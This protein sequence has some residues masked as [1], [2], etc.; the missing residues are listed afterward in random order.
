MR[1]LPGGDSDGATHI[2][3]MVQRICSLSWPASG[4]INLAIG[5]REIDLGPEELEEVIKQIR[6]CAK[7]TSLQRAPPNSSVL[8]FCRQLKALEIQEIPP[9]AYQLLLFTMK[10]M[11]GEILKGIADFFDELEEQ[12]AAAEI[13]ERYCLSV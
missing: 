6:K 7:T 4:V 12:R 5:L 9:L 1:G 11:K 2:R 13:T 3:N 8:S 10:G